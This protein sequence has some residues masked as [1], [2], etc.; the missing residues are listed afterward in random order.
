MR[1]RLLLIIIFVI[2]FSYGCAAVRTCG[3]SADVSL[4]KNFDIT[5]KRIAVLPLINSGNTGINYFASDHLAQSLMEMGFTIVERQ[6]LQTL[7]NELKLDMSGNLSQSDLIKIGQLS[8]I[9]TLVFGSVDYIGYSGNHYANGISVRFVDIATGEVF[10]S[11]RC[12]YIYND[13]PWGIG[14]ICCKMRDKIN[15]EVR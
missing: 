11:G 5:K 12:D 14:E 2:S 6:Q 4:G 9:D 10:L 8:R 13:I 1:L 15:S 3:N 7:F